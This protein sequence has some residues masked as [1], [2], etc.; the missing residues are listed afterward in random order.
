[1]AA[2]TFRTGVR[3]ADVAVCRAYAADRPGAAAV[4]S[5]LPQY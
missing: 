4:D 1:M 3:T 2:S 5:Q